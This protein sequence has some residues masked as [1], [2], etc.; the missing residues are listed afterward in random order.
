MFVERQ[1]KGEDPVPFQKR[2]LA[3]KTSM[4]KW[5]PWRQKVGYSSIKSQSLP[6]SKS[7]KMRDLV[8]PARSLVQVRTL[9]SSYR[10]AAAARKISIQC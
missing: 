1:Q 8:G 7:V 9:L 10:T 4:S 2:R 3:K 6:V 5:C